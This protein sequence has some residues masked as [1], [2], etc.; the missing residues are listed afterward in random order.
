MA[1]DVVVIVGIGGMGQAIARRQGSGRTLLLADFNQDTLDRVS[2]ALTGDGYTV[3]TVQVNVASAED[4]RDLARRAAE[5]GRVVQLVHTAGLSPAQASAEDVL[6]VDLLGVALI[7]DAFGTVIA[8]GG[9]G[10]VIASMAGHMFPPL[11]PEQEYALAH[12]PAGE[13]LSLPHVSLESVTDSASAYGLA[14]QANHCRVK[15]ASVAWG[16]RGARVNSISPGCI[17]TPMG[18]LELESPIGEGIRAI[19]AMSAARRLGTPDEIAAATAFLLG[20]DAGFITGTDLLVDGGAVAAVKSMV[21]SS[22]G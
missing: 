19:V 1:A 16:L 17:S 7:L 8:P 21:M 11:T 22:A 13:L 20:P 12:T 18:S 4:V 15:S 5:L 2:G 9:A 14:K 3:H 10:V 6:Q